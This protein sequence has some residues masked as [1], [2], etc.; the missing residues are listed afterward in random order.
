MQNIRNLI[1][2][3]GG[4]VLNLDLQ[5]TEQAF[6]RLAGTPENHRAIAEQLHRVEF[7]ERF[8][9]GAFS[10]DEFLGTLRAHHPQ[11]TEAQLREAWSAMLLDLPLERVALLRR[12]SGQFRLFLLSNTNALHVA[13]FREIVRAQHGPLDFDGLFEQAWYSH[14]IG[15]RKPHAEVYQ[16]VLGLAGLQA[17]ETLFVDD[18]PP[19]IAGAASVGIHAHLHVANSDLEASLRGAGL[20]FS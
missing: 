10:G 8:E 19:N 14:L 2:D 9:I 16:H 18:N 11:A 13:D 17:G 12:L 5:R 15:R 3:L 7:F 6:A 1:F 20:H 4:V